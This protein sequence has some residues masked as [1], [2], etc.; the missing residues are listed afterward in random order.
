MHSMTR[1]S[2]SRLKLTLVIFALAA[3]PLLLSGCANTFGDSLRRH[4]YCVDRAGVMQFT[5]DDCFERTHGHREGMNEGLTDEGVPA[6]RLATLNRCVE[7]AQNQP[8]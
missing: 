5:V 3:S 4:P 7:A 1:A 8:D 6:A 2:A